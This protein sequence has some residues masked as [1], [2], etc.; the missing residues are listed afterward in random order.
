MQSL[1]VPQCQPCKEIS[2]G[3]IFLSAAAKEPEVALVEEEPV[4]SLSRS[5]Q[6]KLEP[7]IFNKLEETLLLAFS[8]SGSSSAAPSASAS[9]CSPLNSHGDGKMI[10]RS[11]YS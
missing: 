2:S 11:K 4:R 10:L 8:N 3:N 7:L 5:E 1:E 6:R 9:T